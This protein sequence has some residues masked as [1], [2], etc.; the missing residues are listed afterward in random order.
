MGN[1]PKMMTLGDVEIG[2]KVLHPSGE[3]VT[4]TDIHEQG[5]E[6]LYRVWTDDDEYLDA[7]LDHRFRV[8][9]EDLD[10][11]E[12]TDDEF[13]EIHE[14]RPGRFRELAAEWRNKRLGVLG[15]SPSTFIKGDDN[16]VRDANA[17]FPNEDPSNDGEQVIESS[18]SV[19]ALNGI[20]GI[21]LAL[22]FVY[23]VPK[24]NVKNIPTPELRVP[25][26][27]VQKVEKLL[28]KQGVGFK[29]NNSESTDSITRL[30]ITGSVANNIKLAYQL[31]SD[32]SGLVNETSIISPGREEK[33][34]KNI[35]EILSATGAVGVKRAGELFLDKTGWSQKGN[36]LYM[37][38]TIRVDDIVVPA[39]DAGANYAW[40]FMNTTGDEV[41]EG[42]MSWRGVITSRQAEHDFLSRGLRMTVTRHGK[43]SGHTMLTAA[44]LARYGSAKN[45]LAS[46]IP[47][48]DEEVM[49]GI[50]AGGTVV[51]RHGAV[52]AYVVN[53]EVSRQYMKPLGYTI[54]G[55]NES[56]LEITNVPDYLVENA[57]NLDVTTTGDT[58]MYDA[59]GYPVATLPWIFENCDTGTLH[60]GTAMQKV[61]VAPTAVIVQPILSEKQGRTYVRAS[62]PMDLY[63]IDEVLDGLG[64][65]MQERSDRVPNWKKNREAP[66][67]DGLRWSTVTVAE[68][69]DIIEKVDRNKAK[70]YGGSNADVYPKLSNNEPMVVP[71]APG[72]DDLPI[73]PYV[74]GCWLGDGDTTSGV[75]GTADYEFVKLWEDRG[76]SVTTK[77]RKKAKSHYKDF[78][79]CTLRDADG[80]S[81][82]VKLTAIGFP[83]SAQVKHIDKLDRKL[84]KYIPDEYKYASVEARLELLRGILDTDGTH[85]GV[86][87]SSY[88]NLAS[89]IVSLMRGLG[90]RCSIKPKTETKRIMDG[91]VKTYNTNQITFN[92]DKLRI[93]NIQR[94]ID[95]WDSRP[96]WQRFRTIRRIEKLEGKFESRCITVDA[97]DHVFLAGNGNIATSNSVVLH[98]Q[99]L[100]LFLNNSPS[101][102]QVKI[103]EPKVGTQI[104]ENVD[105]VTDYV[106]SWFPRE[107]EFFEAT[108][109]LVKKETDE[110]IRRN[111]LMRLH[112]GRPEKLA[113]ARQIALTEGPQKDGS[114]H[115]LMLPFHVVYMEECAMLFAPSPNKEEKEIQAEILYYVTKLARESRS[116][117]IHM[118]LATQYPTNAS[119][120]SVI[121][122][123]CRR[124][125]LKTQDSVASLVIINEPGLENLVYKGTGKLSQDGVYRDFKGF[126]IEHEPDHNDVFI[127]LD[128]IGTNGGLFN[129]QMAA[130]TGKSTSGG[131]M[132]NYVEVPEL[133]ESLFA[134]WSGGGM[135]SV[136][137]KVY[138]NGKRTGDMGIDGLMVDG[139]ENTAFPEV[140]DDALRASIAKRFELNG[141]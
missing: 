70:S 118:V 19:A 44:P 96:H 41:R 112:P 87:M 14:E 15:K 65:I 88:N 22:V 95:K 74:L 18:R 114:P 101:D 64:D 133:N 108:L 66:D 11:I 98:N 59:N 46:Y 91:P 94:K 100:Q 55:H 122:Q 72:I 78:W 132:S 63:R 113:E 120:P 38:P 68:L 109:D 79:D 121:R 141:S 134:K 31:N 26:A 5:E 17:W 27:A 92:T 20:P 39:W 76:Y 12:L 37:S 49:R 45:F 130:M 3:F 32:W 93:F 81:L 60:R 136:L 71:G 36:Y 34:V 106:D 129:D 84:I 29:K 62:F 82:R 128:E 28:S 110:M 47:T 115:P 33:L 35:G 111:K 127:A 16:I 13:A 89:D 7:S 80:E 56:R 77:K 75:I 103:I 135:G 51:S 48:D 42:S 67:K 86:I 23:G 99:L 8:I 43:G 97:E 105:N 73:H 24:S 85:S 131:V 83:N 139:T 9:L 117:G 123:Q 21:L 40:G 125:G 30:T 102:L 1:M 25:S 104:F 124:Y 138:D 2:D 107:G 116:A 4:V 53:N 10:D 69:I 52:T 119:L 58:H 126:L 90:M 50:L 57:V 61:D 137:K 6:E 140:N 54:G